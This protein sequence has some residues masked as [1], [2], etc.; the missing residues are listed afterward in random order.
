M[1]TGYCT[2]VIMIETVGGAPKVNDLNL[3][4]LEHLVGVRMGP[5]FA[6][7]NIADC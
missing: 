4:E 6:P 3:E 1:F 5:K 2:V 7:H